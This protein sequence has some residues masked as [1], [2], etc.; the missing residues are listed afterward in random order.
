MAL[1]HRRLIR[2]RET[3]AAMIGGYCRGIHGTQ[4]GLCAE[5]QSL[6]DYATNRL[7]RC[8]FQEKKPTCAKCP[9]HCYQP[10]IREQIKAVM[11]YAGPRMFWR[12]PV[13]SVR[14]FLDA[15]RKAPPVPK[16]GTG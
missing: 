14:H 10:Q 6:M 4:A 11:R 15:Y 16:K 7:E 13:L 9:I 5:C 1:N 3:I 8:P 2:E 12:H